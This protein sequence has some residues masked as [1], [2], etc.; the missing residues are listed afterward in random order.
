MTDKLK[1]GIIGLGG[2]ASIHVP[3]W[4]ASPYAELFAGSDIYPSVFPIWKEKHGLTKFYDNPVDL[5]NDPEI[6]IIDIC[7]PNMYHAE[8][9]IAALQAGKHVICEK[10]LA[11]TPDDIRRMI[12]ARDKSSKMLMTAQHFRFRG[13]SQAMKAEIDQGVLGKVYHGRAWWIRRSGAPVGPTFIYKKNSGGGPCIDLGVHV[14]DLSLWLMGHPKP[15]TVSGTAPDLLVHHPGAFS[16]WGRKLIPQDYDV[17]DF[18]AALI[19]FEGGATLSLEVSWM[20][21]HKNPEDVKVWLYGVEGGCEWP[22]AEFIEN[23]YKTRQM[24]NRTLTL[25]HDTM[26][27][28]ALECVEFAKA[29]AEGLPSPVPAEQSL[30]VQAILDGIYRSHQ[31]GREV[32]IKL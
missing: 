1:V 10:P 4:V 5:I 9:T 14:L 29:I 17:E 20:L 32:E 13:D 12:E 28:H 2:I 24:V 30:A 21:N 27:P 11:P 23:Q 3:G 26:E 15:V 7:S 16:S 6:D 18:A 25:T 31:T 19:R 8:Q 22:N